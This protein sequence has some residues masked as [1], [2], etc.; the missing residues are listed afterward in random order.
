MRKVK[1]LAIPIFGLIFLISCGRQINCPDFKQ[2]IMEWIPYQN[3][4]TIKLINSSNDSI[5]KLAIDEVIIEHTTH[6]MT[7]LDCGTCDDHIMINGNETN[8]TDLQIDIGLYE[9]NIMHRDF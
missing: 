2:E 5:I 4:D 3:N 8:N 9:N 6:Y 7:N 1:Q